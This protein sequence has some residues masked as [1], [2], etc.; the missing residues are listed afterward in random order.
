[1]A[2]ADPALAEQLADWF[3]DNMTEHPTVWT[4]ERVLE[5]L[6]RCGI[7]EEWAVVSTWPDGTTDEDPR[8]L[9]GWTGWRGTAELRVQA[10]AREPEVW[11]NTR[12]VRRFVITTPPMEVPT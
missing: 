4:R 9:M 7:R 5:V 11:T 6:E 8:R 12:M 2:V 1:M 10:R 3:I